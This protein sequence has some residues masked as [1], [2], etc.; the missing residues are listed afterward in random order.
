LSSPELATS[1]DRATMLSIVNMVRQFKLGP[2]TVRA[3]KG[4]SFDMQVGD[5]VAVVGGSG[6][7]KST[8]MNVV[9]LLDRPTSGEYYLD[10]Q[11]VS[12]LGDRRLSQIRNR[13]IGFV[14]QAFHLLPRLT[15]RENVELPLIYQGTPARE[16][17]ERA[18]AML[19]RVGL[20]D[21]E[22]HR[23]LE[24]SGGQQQRVA[25]A[26]A[27]VTRPRLLLADEPTGA[28]DPAMTQEVLGLF[29]DL[30]EKDGV[31]ILIITHDMKVAAR[32]KRVV[33]IQDGNIIYE[34]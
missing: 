1:R 13:A 32:A 17:R 20:K 30:N 22:D 29:T 31:S 2:V 26:R 16:R 7:G 24:L 18:L 8:L 28:L 27:L 6:S 19:E 23:P 5:F 11:E 25:I 4:V 3:L 14:F 10:G 12:R 9:G 34:S 21:R 33:R 15:A